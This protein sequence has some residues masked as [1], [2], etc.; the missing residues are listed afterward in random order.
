ME[1]WK[2]IPNS[3]TPPSPERQTL[4]MLVIGMTGVGK[5]YAT[6]FEII[7]YVR[8]NMKTG[9][10]GRRAYLFD[11]NVEPDYVKYFPRTVAPDALQSVTMPE[12]RRVLPI[13][14]NGTAMDDAQMRGMAVHLANNVKNGLLILEDV[15]NYY[16]G[17]KGREISKL[18]TSYR[19][20]SQDVILTHQSLSPVQTIEFQ[21]CT[22]I[23]LHK[24]V[25]SV[26]RIA[27]RV[28]NY[29][30]LK[31]SELIIDEQFQL[32]EQY[33]RDG[34]LTE[35]QYQ[36]RRSYCVLINVRTNRIIG[37]FSK[38][39]FRRNTKK[40]L[41]LNKKKIKDYIDMN[42]DD[43]TGKPTY[44]RTQAIEKLIDELEMRYFEGEE[45]A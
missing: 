23:R 5:S 8:D 38:E 41:N 3:D 35:E 42:V 14:P 19:H 45:Y 18:F 22:M 16:R 34:H 37:K 9:K 26:D 39:C 33:F 24:T 30:I 44:S 10:R 27:D 25:D 31:I 40:Y 13:N 43:E 15:D 4:I 17:S 28:P 7:A 20:R 36:K 21:N 29:E 1:N 2:Y 12:C 32:A 6:I 11:V